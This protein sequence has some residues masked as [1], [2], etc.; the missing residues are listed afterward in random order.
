MSGGTIQMVG[1][2][3]DGGVKALSG[4]SWNRFIPFSPAWRERKIA[5]KM[6]LTAPTQNPAPPTQLQAQSE[7]QPKSQIKLYKK[8]LRQPQQQEIAPAQQT[9]VRTRTGLQDQHQVPQ[10]ALAQYALHD[11][12]GAVGWSPPTPS[13]DRPYPNREYVNGQRVLAQYGHHTD[14]WAVKH[15][16]Y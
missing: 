15:P 14:K 12:K 6:K 13:V 8:L 3:D 4:K 9:S 11:N 7:A 2:E 10:K 1:S 5:R 16:V